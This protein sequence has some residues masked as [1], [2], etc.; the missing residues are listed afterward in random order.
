MN[1][2]SN[3]GDIN[4]DGANDYLIGIPG[5]N[6][7]AGSAFIISGKV[8]LKGAPEA[9]E[10]FRV[11]GNPGDGIGS[12]LCTLGDLNGDGHADFAVSASAGQYVN[13]YSGLDGSVLGTIIPDS[14]EVG[15]DYGK[16][17]TT[18]DLNGDG[19]L[20]LAVGD[21]SFTDDGFIH[22]GSVQMYELRTM[23]DLAVQIT[24]LDRMV[25][26]GEN[27]FGADLDRVA[28]GSSSDY[29]LVGAP[30]MTATPAQNAASGTVQLLRDDPATSAYDLQSVLV[31]EDTTLQNTAGQFGVSVATIG[32]IRGGDGVDE[33]VVGAPA[34]NSN[35][36]GAGTVTVYD[37]D[38]NVILSFVGSA[39]QDGLGL[40]VAA[41]GDADGD[42]VPDFLASAPGLIGGP[43]NVYIFSG[44][45]GTTLDTLPGG[46]LDN[47]FGTALACAGD[48]DR[49]GSRDVMIADFD[50]RVG[51][52]SVRIMRPLHSLPYR[53]AV[54][55]TPNGTKF[56]P[57]HGVTHGPLHKGK[58]SK[59]FDLTR[60]YLTN[61]EGDFTTR[62]NDL[63]I[64][65]SRIHTEGVGDM[66]YLWKLGDGNADSLARDYSAP[67]GEMANLDNYS[68]HQM[69][70]RMDA[71]ETMPSHDTI[72]R[73]GHD[74]AINPDTGEW[75][76]GFYETPNDID[77]FSAVVAG[78]MK[79]YNQ[80]WGRAL[81]QNPIRFVELWNEPHLESFS[82]TGA[83]FAD[84]HIKVLASLDRELDQNGD[85]LADEITMLTPVA[86][87]LVGGFSED[88]LNALD[89]SFDAENPQKTR[90]E[91][92]VGHFYG[93]DPADFLEKMEFYDDLFLDIETN[94]DIFKT[95]PGLQVEWPKI[96]VTE[97]NRTIEE[98]AFTYASMP[99]IM[100]TFFYMNQVYAGEAKRHD[101]RDLKVE[102]A[103]AQFFGP[104][105][106]WRAG[107]NPVTGGLDSL[108]NHAG[109]AWEIYGQTL[110]QD[111]TNRLDVAGTFHEGKIG[112][113][114]NP[115]K[116]F[117][118]M[119][120][121]SETEDLVVL[122]VSSVYLQERTDHP[123]AQNQSL[124]LPYVVDVDSLG[125]VPQSIERRV[126]KAEKIKFREG[127]GAILV[128]IPEI[129]SSEFPYSG[130]T[131]SFQDDKLTVSV[132]D[133]IENTYEVIVIRGEPAAPGPDGPDAPG[134]DSGDDSE[135]NVTPPS[136]GLTLTPTVPAGEVT[137]DRNQI[138]DLNRTNNVIQPVQAPPSKASTQKKSTTKKAKAKKASGGN[139]SKAKK[140]RSSRSKKARQARARNRR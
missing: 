127:E 96:W 64:P 41:M 61:F 118:V 88:F 83:E 22:T 111:A 71:V 44:A 122:V 80:G 129:G 8:A 65:N 138:T 134:D 95:G 98:Y 62:Y 82:G 59:R 93:N 67:I 49:D 36:E 34:L 31:I 102:M 87:G 14:A 131:S 117:T 12:G 29:L 10:L 20:E 2:V 112:D 137:V 47:H 26:V 121:R 133:M 119:A 23:N 89:S 54:S 73:I 56:A 104:N 27:W 100:N 75:M 90:L 9:L 1:R 63:K 84:M 35:G 81:P 37:V 5:S 53:I 7:N 114:A 76:T 57:V 91:A 58:W 25:G 11:E 130:W 39:A 94:R 124:R 48:V 55:A 51:W 103:G 45:D 38:G 86:P 72:W 19:I 135:D 116:D 68:F 139:K 6:S 3:A 33:F 17:L 126:Q 85:G 21:P 99:H 28:S 105:N 128:S 50:P 106:M 43:G 92:V 40:D 108:A 24:T 78:V 110:Y 15:V 77:G 132:G 120:G 136:E 107:I 70:E 66:N 123:D 46:R 125:F 113:N 140:S 60:F 69:D 79:H 97:W 18:V 52:S 13:L 42:L 101:G 115:I 109:L 32:D 30:R 4:N 74:K 16:S